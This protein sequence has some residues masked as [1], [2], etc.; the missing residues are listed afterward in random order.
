[1]VLI[2]VT[3]VFIVMRLLPG[4]PVR[5]MLGPDAPDETIEALRHNLGLDQPILTQ[6]FFYLRELVSGNWGRSLIQGRSVIQEITYRFPLT[7]ELTLLSMGIGT[8]TGVFVGTIAA[9]NQGKAL[10]HLIRLGSFAG[11]SMPI[12]WVGVLFQLVFGL[13]L[14]LL[15][16]SGAVDYYAE[17]TRVTGL[18]ILDSLLTLN[19]KAF[20]NTVSHMIMPSMVLGIYIMVPVARIMRGE[21]IKVLDEDYILTARA[22]GLPERVVMYKHAF[23]NAVLPVITVAGLHFSGLLG[24]AVLTETVFSLPGMGRLLASSVMLRDFPMVQGCVLFFALLVGAANTLVDMT[25]RFVDPR[26]KY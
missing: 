3:M 2:V 17:P 23:R 5:V 26:I 9:T 12:F 24:G 11:Y 21:M 7:L 16:I 25:Y 8:L 19:G 10:D 15:P 18:L 4:D 6:F 14:G 20:L 22:K 1:M 13:S